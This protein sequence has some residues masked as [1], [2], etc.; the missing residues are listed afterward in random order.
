MST[1]LHKALAS[2]LA[3]PFYKNDHHSS[4]GVTFKHDTAVALRLSLAGFQEVNANVFSCAG[5]TTVLREWAE[6]SNSTELATSFS[7]LLPGTFVLQ[8]GGSQCTPDCLLR[9]H[10]GKYIGLEFK[11]SE[12]STKPTWNDNTPKDEFI[13]VFCSKITDE[14]TIFFG[15]DVITAEQNILKAQCYD[16]LNSVIEKYKPLFV[17]ADKNHRGFIP[18]WRPKTEQGG[19]GAKTNYFTHVDRTKCEQ[20]VLDYVK[21]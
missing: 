20:A 9:D 16:E 4:A 8:P 15:K 18:G 1:Q 2:I 6:T 7:S 5:K 13:Y 19:G 14:T 10:N 21:Q 12:T 3:M 11:S 17:A